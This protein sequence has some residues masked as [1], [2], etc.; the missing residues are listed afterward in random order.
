[1]TSECFCLIFFELGNVPGISGILESSLVLG[2]A[3][4]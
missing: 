3:M 4:A 1:M 2:I